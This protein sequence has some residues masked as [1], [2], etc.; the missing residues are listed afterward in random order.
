[1]REKASWST[2]EEG[3]HNDDAFFN[4][5]HIHGGEIKVIKRYFTLIWNIFVPDWTSSPNHA[6]SEAGH[7]PLLPSI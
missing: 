6:Q 4:I 7:L 1:S 2:E 3:S 5:M